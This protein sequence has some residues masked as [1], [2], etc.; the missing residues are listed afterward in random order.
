MKAHSI[1][2]HIL[3]GIAK[4]RLVAFF[5][6]KDRFFLLDSHI[7]KNPGYFGNAKAFLRY[8]WILGGGVSAV[9]EGDAG[10][11]QTWETFLRENEGCW[12][13]GFLGYDLKNK[14]E[15]LSTTS[16]DHLQL[17]GLLWWKP[18]WVV[19]S[20]AGKMEVWTD[21]EPEL[22]EE[23]TGVIQTG[24]VPVDN[25]MPEGINLLQR[26]GRQSYLDKIRGLKEHIRRGDIYEINFCMEFYAGNVHTDAAR[27]LRK[28]SA[29]SP[30][31]FSAFINTPEFCVI[32]A[33]PE[34]FLQKSGNTLIAQ[35]MKGTIRR[36]TSPEED[37]RLIREL[38]GHPKEQSENV[39]IVD[40]VR[41]D[42][43]RSASKGSVEVEELFGIHTFPKVHQMVSTVRSQLRPEM[44]AAEAIGY[45]FPMGS[46]T[47]APKIRAMQLIDEFE[48]NARGIF[49]GSIGYM[50]PC[51]DMDMN[52][53]I[54]TLVY[55]KK[56]KYL[57][58]SV[59]SAITIDADPEK[60]YEECMLKITPMLRALGVN[61]N[62]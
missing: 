17:P 47:G 6:E 19:T 10:F 33:S 52:V 38:R 3:N 60:E 22:V 48:E 16:P 12:T 29:E 25:E 1:D 11:P 24:A 28:V 30:M 53:V 13:V 43:A 31:P 15:N 7:D 37:L 39:M 58:L 55:N 57:S 2:S 59:G 20:A 44:S 50:D 56:T 40:L 8:D 26:T 35:P 45:A 41:N 18:R 9:I 4:D 49:S 36:G 61:G 27:L 23:I 32:S 5:A 46:M 51:G 21:D 34:R 42:F 14:L 54:R 62:K